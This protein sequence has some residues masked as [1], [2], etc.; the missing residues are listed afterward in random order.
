MEC[1]HVW[2]MTNTKYGFMVTER[3]RHCSD[4]MVY[5][6]V[7]EHFAEG[8][9]YVEDDHIW[10][11]EEISQVAQFD[12]QCKH[13]QQLV[14]LDNL[15]GFMLCTGCSDDCQIQKT[16]RELATDSIWVYVAFSSIPVK[17]ETRVEYNQLKAL[18][19][20]FNQRRKSKKGGIKFVSHE[21][22]H[23]FNLCLGEIIQD[24]GMLSM[25]LK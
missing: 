22:I 18:T 2:E 12:L 16:H 5:F 19:A 23:D 13:C 3:C 7:N 20:Y 15:I 25:E 11:I 21:L 10:L 4:L 17:P 1:K 14:S 8:D 6:T 24:R 9:E